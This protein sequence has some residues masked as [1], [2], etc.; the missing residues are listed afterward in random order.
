M[1]LNSMIQE[2]EMRKQRFQ[3][4]M[5]QYHSQQPQV[6]A[7]W[8]LLTPMQ[9]QQWNEWNSRLMA[10]Q[11]WLQQAQIQIQQAQ[12]QQYESNEN[13]ENG[14]EENGNESNNGSVYYNAPSQEENVPDFIFIIEAHGGAGYYAEKIQL[15]PNVV[16]AYPYNPH[17]RCSIVQNNSKINWD[18]LQWNHLFSKQGS[19]RQSWQ[20]FQNQIAEKE[21]TADEEF[22]TVY[23]LSKQY[24]KNFIKTG[25]FPLKGSQ[26]ERDFKL[27]EVINHLLRN[28]IT[29]DKK[30]AI[31]IN[32][33][34]TNE[35]KKNTKKQYIADYKPG[36]VYG[37]E[38]PDARAFSGTTRGNVSRSASA[39]SGWG[40][41]GSGGSSGYGMEDRK[42]TRKSKKSRKSGIKRKKTSK[43]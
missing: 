39:A 22:H 3:A 8:S 1:D 34:D 14:N 37:I 23:I 40:R 30:Y 25:S 28:F 27:S 13:E 7:N 15:P 21:L 4:E 18:Y 26:K 20:F 11:G 6:L 42:R 31:L 24:G 38:N 9:Q 2:F 32:T 43:N 5:Q 33:C 12:Q 19:N 35:I 17:S 10:E 36:A 41:G 16:A 29:H